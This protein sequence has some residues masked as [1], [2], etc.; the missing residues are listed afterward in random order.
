MHI[1]ALDFKYCSGKIGTFKQTTLF[2]LKNGIDKRYD[3]RILEKQFNNLMFK[4]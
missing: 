4:S 2:C 3:V 1:D